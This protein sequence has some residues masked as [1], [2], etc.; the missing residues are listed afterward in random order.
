MILRPQ[1]RRIRADQLMTG[2]T[3]GDQLVVKLRAKAP[4]FLDAG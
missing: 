3:A 1:L 2:E 4:G